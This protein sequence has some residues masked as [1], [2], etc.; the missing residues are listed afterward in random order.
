MSKRDPILLWYSRY[1]CNFLLEGPYVEFCTN[2]FNFIFSFGVDFTLIYT[3]LDPYAV[4]KIIV[5]GDIRTV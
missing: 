2:Y 5:I 3:P 4:N 1:A